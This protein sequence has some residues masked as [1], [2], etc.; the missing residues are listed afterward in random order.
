M[1]LHG[2]GPS[3]GQGIWC[4]LNAS[5]LMRPLLE[6]GPPVS[7]YITVPPF[8]TDEVAAS[9]HLPDDPASAARLSQDPGCRRG[10]LSSNSDSK[11]VLISYDCCHYHP[12]LRGWKQHSCSLQ[13][14]QGSCAT[15]FPGCTAGNTP[16]LEGPSFLT[17]LPQTPGFASITHLFFWL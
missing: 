17:A 1:R 2:L 8:C 5:S 11:S 15:P 14:P 10:K 13:R 9:L 7:Q 12:K 4:P 16:Q 3:W 6:W